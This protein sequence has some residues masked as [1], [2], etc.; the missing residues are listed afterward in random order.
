MSRFV[1]I[2]PLLAV[3]TGCG[4]WHF[5]F[6]N[7]EDLRSPFEKAAQEGNV[8]EVKRLLAAGA[9]PNDRGGVFGS[10]L[11]AAAFGN[12]NVETIQTLLSAGANPNGREP[13][14]NKCWASPLWHV[15]LDGDVE[16]ARA[17]LDA[18]AS[19]EQP[20]CMKLNAGFLQVPVLDLLVERGLNLKALD[21]NGR[22]QLHLAL[23]PPWVPPLEG[24]EYLIR[25]GVPVN[26]RDRAGKTPLAYWREPRDFQI[27]WFRR[28]LFQRFSGE[29]LLQRDRENHAEVSAVLERAG[30]SL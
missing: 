26:A 16:S 17:L 21:E 10:P 2:L 12:S 11:T 30:A 14:G 7:N 22:N 15:A 27:H 25:A 29:S 1:A 19:I 20:H 4:G 24:I 8:A 13:A 9:D 3:L 23:A 28:W 5:S 6:G 18:G